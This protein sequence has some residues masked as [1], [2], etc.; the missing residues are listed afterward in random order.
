MI[1]LDVDADIS[2]RDVVA[3]RNQLRRF[4]GRHDA[5]DAR[6]RNC[7]ALGERV[8]LDRSER[9]RAHGDGPLGTSNALGLRFVSDVDHSRAAVGVSVRQLTHLRDDASLRTS[10]ELINWGLTLVSVYFCA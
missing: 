3:E 2:E 9:V 4:L 1:S 8:E 5:G 7:V 6:S 10:R